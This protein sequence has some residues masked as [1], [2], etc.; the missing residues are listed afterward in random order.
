MTAL[1][2]IVCA[3]T[4]QLEQALPKPESN[5]LKEFGVEFGPSRTAMRP[6]C[7]LLGGVSPPFAA[8]PPALSHLRLLRS[9]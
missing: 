9:M 8:S 5:C 7:I 2:S 4:T 1:I 3:S 6:A